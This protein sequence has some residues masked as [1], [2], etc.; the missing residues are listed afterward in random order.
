MSEWE[1]DDGQDGACS[2]ELTVSTTCY[3]RHLHRANGSEPVFAGG[4][5]ATDKFCTVRRSRGERTRARPVLEPSKAESR[6]IFG[7]ETLRPWRVTQG[8]RV[9]LT[10]P[11]M[12]GEKRHRCTGPYPGCRRGLRSPVPVSRKR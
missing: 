9:R 4:P 2:F 6:F 3:K 1:L 11:L 10:Q 8:G 7:L 12:A 5:Q